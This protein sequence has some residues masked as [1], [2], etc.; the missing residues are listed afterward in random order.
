[1]T[2]STLK[3]IVLRFINHT[4]CRHDWLALIF[5]KALIQ[6]LVKGKEN[7]YSP[8]S[9]Y[10]HISDLENSIDKRIEDLDSDSV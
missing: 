6:L 9:R 5:K 1:M 8:S 7:P 4:F 2:M 3:F 10:F